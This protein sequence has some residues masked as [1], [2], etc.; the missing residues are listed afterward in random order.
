[1][2]EGACSR[3]EVRVPAGIRIE[4]KNGVL[5]LHLPKKEKSL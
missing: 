4:H 3:P 1:V 2:I 5:Y